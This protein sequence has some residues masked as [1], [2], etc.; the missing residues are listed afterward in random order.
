MDVNDTFK[1]LLQRG[2]AIPF[3]NHQPDDRY[4]MKNL[5]YGMTIGNAITK[6]GRQ[7][8]CWVGGGDSPKAFFL[9]SYSDDDA[10]TWTE[11]VLVIDPHDTTLPCDRSTLVGTL[12][13]DPENRLWLFFNQSLEQFDGRSSNWFIRCDD[14]DSS[15]LVWTEPRYISYGCTLN[16]PIVMDNGEWLLPVSLW[17][18]RYISKPF[19]DCY[20]QLDSE[21]MAHLYVSSDRGES[22]TRRGGVFF[23]QSQFD[24]H[25][26]VQLKDGRLWMIARTETVLMEAFSD[27]RGATWTEPLEARIQSVPARFHLRRLRSGRIL[28]VKNGCLLHERPENRSFMTAFLSDDEGLSWSEGF[29]LDERHEVSYPDSA[30]GEDGMIYIT[31]DRNRSK[32]GEILIASLREE[33]ILLGRIHTRGALVGRVIRKPGKLCT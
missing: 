8:V 17:T 29:V 3:I 15:K 6:G 26:C 27:D 2:Y 10:V 14:P 16:K 28:L 11:P 22:W 4:K 18:R 1:T 31:Y 21:R 23:P 32:D 12:W 30:E 25:M 24:E 7:F 19:S 13:V 9:L 5:N 20:H 33:D